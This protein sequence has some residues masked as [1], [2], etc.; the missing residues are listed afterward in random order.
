MKTNLIVGK[1]EG[2]QVRNFSNEFSKFIQFVDA[3]VAQVQAG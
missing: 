3:V 2:L 1:I